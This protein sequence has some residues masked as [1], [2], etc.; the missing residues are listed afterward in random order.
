MSWSVNV[1]LN[2]YTRRIALHHAIP[3]HTVVK[4]ASHSSPSTI[5]SPS[6]LFHNKQSPQSHLVEAT[7]DKQHRWQFGVTTKRRPTSGTKWKEM[8]KACGTTTPPVVG[9][10]AMQVYCSNRQAFC[11]PHSHNINDIS[12]AFL[13]TQPPLGTA[14]HCVDL[15]R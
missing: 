2:D 10:Y 6:T 9:V 12:R 15:Q 14:H 1:L 13:L 7:K 8:N 5:S 11:R 4:Q 3:H